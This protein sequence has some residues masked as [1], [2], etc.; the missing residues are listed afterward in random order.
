MRGLVQGKLQHAEEARRPRDGDG[1]KAELAEDLFP[2]FAGD[3]LFAPEFVED[4]G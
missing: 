4:L 1:D 3:P 2:V